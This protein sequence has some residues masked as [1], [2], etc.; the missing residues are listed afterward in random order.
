MLSGCFEAVFGGSFN[1][2]TQLVEKHAETFWIQADS[3]IEDGVECFNLISVTHTK[4]PLVSQLLPMIQ[5][6]M[7]TMDHLIKRK[8]GVKPTVSE[9]GPLFKINKK[10]LSFLFPEPKT[11][12]LTD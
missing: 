11:Y 5:S 6:G 12:S 1:D 2:N 7:I 10:D 3:V 4:R 9:K 8:G